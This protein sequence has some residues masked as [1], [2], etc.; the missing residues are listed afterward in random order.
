MG[1]QIGQGQY[2]KLS[3]QSLAKWQDVLSNPIRK[4]WCK[5]YIYWIGRERLELIGYDLDFIINELKNL[6]FSMENFGSDI[7]WIIYGIFYT[8]FNPVTI[9]HKIKSFLKKE[10]IY[11]SF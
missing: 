5:R 4:I 9:K 11:P 1:D 3:K 10:R 8:L 6:P 2:K 7:F